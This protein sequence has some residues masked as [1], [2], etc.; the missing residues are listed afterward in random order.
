M[1]LTVDDSKGGANSTTQTVTVTA[2][3]PTNQVPTARFTFA[4]ASPA[5]N[6]AVA[7]DATTSSDPDA[8]DTLTYAWTFGDG[9]TATGATASHTY[10]AAGPF[11]VTLTVDDSK[12]GANSTTQTVTVTGGSGEPTNRAPSAAF[13]P[14]ASQALT[15]VSITLDASASS[16]PDGDALTFAWSFGDT[17]NGAGVSTTKAYPSAGTFTITLVVSD[18]RGGSSSTTREVTIS[19]QPS[20]NLPPIPSVT[21]STLQAETA[22][23]VA[24]DAAASTDPDGD[25]PLLFAWTFG[26][27]TTA[28][29]SQVGKAW[30]A[31]GVFEVVLTVT[32]AKG[33]PATTS[34][35]VTVVPRP[36][37]NQPPT[38]AISGPVS[39]EA[40]LSLAFDGSASTDPEGGALTYE[41]SIGTG[42]PTTGA[43]SSFVFDAPG[44]R[45]VTLTVRDAAGATG[46]AS[47][48]VVVTAAADRQAPFVS[49]AGQASALPGEAVTFTA[50]ATDNVAVAGVDFTAAGIAGIPGAS[51]TSAPYQFTV[52]IPPVA[53]PGQSVS[54]TALARD[55]AGN[56]ASASASVTVS[57]Q[58]DSEPPQVTLLA[59]A[60]TSPGATLRVAAQAVDA[61]GVARVVFLL[62][63][64]E[65]GTDSD[66]PYEVTM[67]VAP[68]TAVGGSL[69]LTARAFDA[70]GNTGEAVC[71]HRR[72][73]DGRH[74]GADDRARCSR[75]SDGGRCARRLGDGHGRRRRGAR[76]VRVRRRGHDGTGEPRRSR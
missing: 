43:T 46:S 50:A 24:F 17:T 7:F 59:P 38:A 41:W 61:V 16:D 26:D 58:P 9:A 63:L 74:G 56:T 28:T 33:L 48:E 18:G 64:A 14:S 15:G 72:R 37:G 36:A 62:G 47:R 12:G 10:T 66:A 45:T 4:P 20:P 8:G 31:Q 69:V 5:V 52:T 3:P 53:S 65:V 27:G 34:R 44:T 73:R 29:G 35:Q 25:L 55:V 13:T 32:D 60:Q 75:R 40:G 57:V 42:A 54:V 11:T 76:R 71:H 39:G 68:D 30:S 51:D 23:A 67:P 2:A 49:L 6:Q 19:A 70:A 1:T 22:Q 21:A